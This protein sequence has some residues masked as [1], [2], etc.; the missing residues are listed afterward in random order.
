EGALRSDTLKPRSLD[1]QLRHSRWY[2]HSHHDHSYIAFVSAYLFPK[3][4]NR[5]KDDAFWRKATKVSSVT[6]QSAE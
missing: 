3:S 2:D 6:A 1:V 4:I 5:D